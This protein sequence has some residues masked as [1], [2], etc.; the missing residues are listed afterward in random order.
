MN[1]RLENF[2]RDHQ[3]DFDFHEPSDKLWK[4]IEKKIDISNRHKFAYYLSRT[5][6]VAAIF[7]ISF[8]IQQYFWGNRNEIFIPEL[9][10]AEL[11]YSGLISLKLEQI[12]PMLSEYPILQEG[13]DHDLS[14]LDSV[15]NGLK[16]D[17]KDNIS[18]QEVLEAMIEN[19]RFRIDI[20]EE[21]VLF[22]ETDKDDFKNNNNSEH[23]L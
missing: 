21:M 19:Y 9:Q 17:L 23:E 10:E 11:Y 14:E 7:I 12:K 20:L 8:A 16:E 22:L 18:N 2:V 5:A 3:Q 13:L 1:D 6:A 4:G 15:Y